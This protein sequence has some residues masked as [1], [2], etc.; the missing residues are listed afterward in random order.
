MP[1]T[2]TGI[3]SGLDVE[4]LVAQLVLA[5]I[6]PKEVRL[7]RR[8]ASYQAEISAYGSIK[9]ALSEFQSKAS[10][11]ADG[12]NYQAKSTSISDYTRLSGSASAG[13]ANGSYEITA[14]SLAAKH[15]LATSGDYASTSAAVGTGTLTFILG[16]TTYDPD[17]DT[18]TDNFA[19]KSGAS[20][21]TVT[22]DSSNNTLSGL[23]DAINAA[24]AGVTA[25]IVYDGGA[26]ELTI[27][28][29]AEGAEN[30]VRITVD[31]DDGTD[32][33]STGLSS[34]AFNESA[35]N[36]LQTRAAADANLT[37]NGL[38]IT[39]S[40][41]TVTDA[42]E[43]ISFT[44]KET[45][46]EPEK[47]TVSDDSGKITSTVQAFVDSYNEL[48]NTINQQTAYDPDAKTSSTLTADGTVRSVLSS[49]RREINQKVIN[50]IASLNYLAQLG[51]TTNTS[52]GKM[53]LD[54]GALTSAIDENPLDVATVL[55]SI[56]QSNSSSLIYV[57][58]N[59]ETEEGSYDV[60]FTPA[61]A[62]TLL[63]DALDN[64]LN[65][66]QNV[67]SY[68]N[69][70]VTVDGT[71]V[72]I[73]ITDNFN[74]DGEAAAGVQSSINAALVAA[75]SSASVTVSLSGASGDQLLITSNSTGADSS[76]SVSGVDSDAA[77]LGLDV[78]T[79]SSGVDAGATLNGVAATVSGNEVTGASGTAMEGLKLK[80]L[81]GA[82]LSD[83]RI[84]F[85]RGIGADLDSLISSLLATDGLIEARLSGLESSIDDI[86]ESRLSLETRASNLEAIYRN[87]FNGLET[88]ISSINETGSFL[89]QA[90][91]TS[92]IEPLSFKKK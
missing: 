57:S 65:F 30:S 89:T 45:F 58:S 73:Q 79:T 40:S 76:V 53:E 67:N 71:T 82:T 9:S 49:L 12:A 66:S 56:G 28:S 11:A 81:G 70:S 1:I 23:R 10:A 42:L 21:V 7:A 4:S 22:I 6:Q 43:N 33:D 63:A 59:S 87:Q 88:L 16:T 69:F 54:S 24:N 48:V 44:L 34:F 64:N 61:T 15:S 90:L 83:A 13:A 72:S 47:I 80:V 14:T 50:P 55:A 32:G 35:T 18:Y 3:G 62:G 60:A 8:E 31:D 52:T 51:I 17:T 91:S 5:E 20:S 26:Y 2:S 37:I 85:S 36:L 84:Y 25:S 41:N 68:A 29:D 39:S 86:E 27:T 46:S 38:S 78:V 75:S 77:R 74:S 19:A 92:F